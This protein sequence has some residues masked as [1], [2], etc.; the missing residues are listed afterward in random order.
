[1]GFIQISKS[2]YN[3]GPFQYNLNI[4]SEIPNEEDMFWKNLQ[5]HRAVHNGVIHEGSSSI[6]S[7]KAL[8]TIK[9]IPNESMGETIELTMNL[10]ANGF[11]IMYA[12]EELVSGL[13][14]EK[15]IDMVKC[16]KRDYE[17]RVNNYRR[18]GFSK[19]GKLSFI[20]KIIYLHDYLSLFF[21][22]TELINIIMPIMYAIFGIW[23]IKANPVELLQF[24]IPNF[25]ACVLWFKLVSGSKKTKFWWNH[26]YNV[27]LSPFLALSAFQALIITKKNVVDKDKKVSTKGKIQFSWE[28]AIPHIILFIINITAWVLSWVIFNNNSLVIKEYLLI[29][30][31]W[32]VYNTFAIFVSIRVCFEKPRFR[33]QERV[34]AKEQVLL[35]FRYN[36]VHVCE[37]LDISDGGCRVLCR[38]FQGYDD[39][40][41]WQTVELHSEKLG[42]IE[43][44]IVW[45]KEMDGKLQYGLKFCNID[46]KM[47]IQLMEYIA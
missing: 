13:K 12:D 3:Q 47:L 2:F 24:W 41:K 19:M 8:K 46:N 27:A 4:L 37:I 17:G 9:N 21:G 34:T 38:K 26:V 10:Q 39:K 20:Q 44:E 40:A 32:S 30:L 23:V 15:F 28:V 45:V 18:I 6:V 16:K 5:K 43:V 36:E 31:I 35:R 22:F 25:I 29:N 11:K 33:N 42:N 7:R 14:P 1:M